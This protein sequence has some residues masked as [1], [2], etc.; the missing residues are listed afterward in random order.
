MIWFDPNENRAETAKAYFCANPVAS[1]CPNGEDNT[2]E[3]PMWIALIISG[4]VVLMTFFAAGFDFL[5]KRRNRVDNQ[6]K[7]AVVELQRRVLA[8]EQTV[9]EKDNK[10][11]QLETDLSFLRRLIEKE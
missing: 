7:Q 8:L 10:V 3:T 11:G 2:E 5:T 1:V 4:G 6:T 9:T